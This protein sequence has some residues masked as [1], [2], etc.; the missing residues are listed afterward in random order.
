MAYI[1]HI[2]FIF[3]LIMNFINNKMI[4]AYVSF[5][6][7]E[8]AKKIAKMLVQNKLAAC[9]KLINGLE[10]FYM[11]EGAL[12]EDKEVY[13]LIKSKEN[14]IEEIKKLLDDNH[15]YKVY[16]FLYYNVES[17]NKKYSEWVDL[18]I[19]SKKDEI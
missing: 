6:E 18:V 17:G 9:V 15:P 11:W 14:K 13:I 5:P 8:I 1:R 7:A 19:D 12:Q 10:S 4:M 16:E 2:I 3:I